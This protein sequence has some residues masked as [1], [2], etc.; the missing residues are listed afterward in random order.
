MFSVQKEYR[1]Y[2]GTWVWGV[3]SLESWIPD[4]NFVPASVSSFGSGNASKY[5]Y[6][7]PV[8]ASPRRPPTF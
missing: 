3:D 7:A 6:T 1:T 4:F 5:L 8:A 2:L